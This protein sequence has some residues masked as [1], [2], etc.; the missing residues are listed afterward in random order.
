MQ[1]STKLL[2]AQ[3]CERAGY[4]LVIDM[5]GTYAAEQLGWPK[6]EA[7]LLGGMLGGAA[8]V[9]PI[10]GG[11]V[12]DK[13]IGC[14]AAL[15]A[16][17]IALLTSYASLAAGAPLVLVAL[18][19]AIGNG[20]YKPA[21][22]ATCGK[23][24]SHGQRQTAMYK[25]YMAINIGA[26]VAPILGEMLKATLGWS[27]AFYASAMLLGTTMLIVRL[28]AV[29]RAA[30][31]VASEPPRAPA[32]RQLRATERTLYGLYAIV[33]VFWIGF[34]QFN[35]TLTFWARD[36]TDRHLLL[37]TIPPAVF[38]ALNS[39]FIIMMGDRPVTWLERRGFT[40][41]FQ[42]EIGM[43]VM[44][45]SYVLM[46]IAAMLST[47]GSASMLWLVAAYGTMSLSEVLIS[48]AMLTLIAE[49]SPPGRTAMHMGLWFGTSAVGHFIAGGVGYAT[50]WIGYVGVFSVLAVSMLAGA[51]G[52]RKLSSGISEVTCSDV[53]Q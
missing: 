40:F 4:Y 35:G 16:G 48:P 36:W 47:Q 38:A 27:A 3:G 14:G 52:M 53:K 10:F 26:L 51:V 20:L 17:A 25:F 5:I 28:P 46:T 19:M 42:L 11:T 32:R 15:L 13:I 23:L 41:R 50:G 37:F 39:A 6:H 34:N 21:A 22:T 12:A 33:T 31:G 29:Q 43:M 18:L 24:A 9:G 45:C 8:Y 7:M 2:I 44:A 1:S 49:T 30:G